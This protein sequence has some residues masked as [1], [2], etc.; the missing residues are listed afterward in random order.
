MRYWTGFWQIAGISEAERYRKR[1]RKGRWNKDTLDPLLNLLRARPATV[2]VCSV[3]SRVWLF[4]TPWTVARQAPLSMG[5]SRQ[6]YWSGVPFPPPGDPPHP[7]IEP[8][9]LYFLH[10]QAD[11]LPLFHLHYLIYSYIL[12]CIESL[13]IDLSKARGKTVKHFCGA[14]CMELNF[15]QKSNLSL[16]LGRYLCKII[17][18]LKD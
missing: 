18:S 13:L 15:F 12:G 6:D 4:A 7:G 10:W 1:K 14:K 3:L 2:H 17:N 8:S 9:S 11:S 5:F 16:N